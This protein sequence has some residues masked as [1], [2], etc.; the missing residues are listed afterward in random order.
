MSKESVYTDEV[1][2]RLSDAY[3][4]ADSD[5]TRANVVEDFAAELGV[6]VQSVRAKLVNLGLYVAKQRKAKDGSEVETKAKIVE[7]IA[8]MIGVPS[9]TIESLEKATKPTLKLIRL[10]LADGE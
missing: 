5:E 3:V 2:A 4:A 6:K 7:S 9:E 8:E 1:V 10:A